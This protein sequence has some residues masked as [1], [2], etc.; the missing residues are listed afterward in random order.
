MSKKI[1][2][3]GEIVRLKSGGPEMTIDYLETPIGGREP[4]FVHCKWFGGRKLEH[5]RFNI[6]AIVIAKEEQK[7]EK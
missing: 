7:S 2:K 3:I 5:G 1:F 6:N 4:E